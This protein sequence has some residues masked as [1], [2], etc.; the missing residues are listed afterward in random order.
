MAHSYAADTD[1]LVSR[2]RKVEGQLRGIQRMLGEGAYCADVLTQLSAA[3]KALEKVGLRLL[4]EH[5]RGCVTEA[6]RTDDQGAEQKI[7]E[8]VRVVERFMAT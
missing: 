1:E 4:H 5:M 6:M 2:L 8:V 3:N 7:D